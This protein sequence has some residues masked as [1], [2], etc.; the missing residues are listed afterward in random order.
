VEDLQAAIRE[1]VRVTRPGGHLLLEL[2]N[3]WSLRYLA[4]KAAGPRN[5]SESRTEADVFTRWDSPLAL[6]S[7][8]TADTELVDVHGLRV[9]TP[10]AGIHRT[11]LL[12]PSLRRAERLASRSPFRYF[13]GF[14]V[15]VL[16]KS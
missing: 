5:I 13:G 6:R 10:F 15:M 3:P 16:R 12:G 7:L 2:Y 1:C 9:L 11:P 14:L 4:K 8:I